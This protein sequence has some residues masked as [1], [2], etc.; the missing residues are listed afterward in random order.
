MCFL[1]KERWST[2]HVEVGEIIGRERTRPFN[3]YKKTLRIRLMFIM[4]VGSFAFKVTV[5]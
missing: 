2:L 1:K 3:L 5:R 4:F